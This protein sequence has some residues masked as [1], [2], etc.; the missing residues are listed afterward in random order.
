M[1]ISFLSAALES[2]A[3][4]A[5]NDWMYLTAIGAGSLLFILVFLVAGP[6]KEKPRRE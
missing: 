4:T 5:S 1:S 6:R 2:P 3:I